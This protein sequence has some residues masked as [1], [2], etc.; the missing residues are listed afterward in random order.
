MRFK[1]SNLG[2]PAFD[3]GAYAGSGAGKKAWEES[4]GA[5]T[6]ATVG[7]KMALSAVLGAAGV[8]ATVPVA[9]WIVA[10]GL[11]AT[12]GI[13]VLVKAYKNSGRAE[14]KKQAEKMGEGGKAFAR[15]FARNSNKSR[16]KINKDITKLREKIAK[17]ESKDRKLGQKRREKRLTTLADQLNANLVLLAMRD[18]KSKAP[19]IKDEVDTIPTETPIQ[20]TPE[21]Q[22]AEA[23]GANWLTETGEIAGVDVPNWALLGGGVLLASGVAYGLYRVGKK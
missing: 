18:A 9:G 21:E 15:E 2:E 20:E 6:M 14:A 17:K 11:L 1:P 10:G 3:V 4:P 13:I 8:S 5:K 12:A 7:G 19:A 16:A 22:V 23:T